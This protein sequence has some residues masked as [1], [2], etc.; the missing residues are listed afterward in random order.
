M[1]LFFDLCAYARLLELPTGNPDNDLSSIGIS[2]SD[3]TPTE[4][5]VV[6]DGA[7]F[8]MDPCAP[9][10]SLLRSGPCMIVILTAAAVFFQSGD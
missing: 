9:R 5:L 1:T 7:V 2:W 8:W 10:L 4:P 3:W 6:D